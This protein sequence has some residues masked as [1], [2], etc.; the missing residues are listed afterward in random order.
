MIF[1]FKSGL[2]GFFNSLVPVSLRTKITIDSMEFVRIRALSVML[3]IMLLLS[4]P[5]A[6]SA[7]ITDLPTT[8]LVLVEWSGVII[9]FVFGMQVFLFYKFN[10]YWLSALAFSSIY[11]LMIVTLVVMSGGDKS[12]MKMLLLTCPFMSF[13][14]SGKHEGIQTSILVMGIGV[15]L[16][17]LQ[18][19]D[20]SAP[21]VFADAN[22][23]LIFS[24]DWV[25]AV[26][27]M[28]FAMMV[29]ESALQGSTSDIISARAR[30]LIAM[31]AAV[32][33][34]GLLV[35]IPIMVAFWLLDM[36]LT[37]SW[38]QN[39][40][41]LALIMIFT[42]QL[43][44]FYR[45]KNQALSGLLFSNSYFLVVILM[46]ISSGGYD[47]PLKYCLLTSPLIS[48]MVG[49]I[50]EGIQHGMFVLISGLALVGCRMTGFEFVD[51]FIGS[52]HPYLIFGSSWIV[53]LGIIMACI[54]LYE[55][56]LQ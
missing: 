8:N 18:S 24:A 45:L 38:W 51:I 42:L 15:V 29:Y 3:A 39:L 32:V 43:W 1:E 49:G 55:R 7:F 22:D 16:A 50:R 28:I 23:Y 36:Q 6:I 44:L 25:I 27:T 21:D 9:F 11:L 13:M 26:V 33:I 30:F 56:E 2:A 20:F 31:L 48:F 52:E 10:N 41:L 17:F 46:V 14:I 47:S 4:I 37:L 40:A 34:L 19:I 35:T 54:V 12:P 5:G 53:T